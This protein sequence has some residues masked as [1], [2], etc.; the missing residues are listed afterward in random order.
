MVPDPRSK[1]SLLARIGIAFIVPWSVALVAIWMG[2][3]F[4]TESALP[5][6]TRAGLMETADGLITLSIIILPLAVWFHARLCRRGNYSL[7][8]H[9]SIGPAIASLG[10]L[11][12]GFA[13]LLSMD[14]DFLLFLRL[15]LDSSLF[16]VIVASAVGCIASGSTWHFV[17]RTLRLPSDEIARRFD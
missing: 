12:A 6:S 11:M 15:M 2:V 1:Q 10:V 16:V 8:A 3:P 17:I 14:S 9:L 7:K 5:L 13:D 4:L